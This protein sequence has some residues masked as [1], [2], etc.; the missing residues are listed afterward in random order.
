MSDDIKRRIVALQMI[1]EMRECSR[2]MNDLV[3]NAFALV[4]NEDANKLKTMV[5]EFLGYIY[6]DIYHKNIIREFP[7]LSNSL[8]SDE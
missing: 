3:I 4:Q 8:E 6:C 5:G 7:E 2:V 1:E